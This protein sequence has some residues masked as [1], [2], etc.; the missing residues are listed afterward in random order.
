[1]NTNSNKKHNNLTS[2]LNHLHMPMMLLVAALALSA[3]MGCTTETTASDAGS[4]EDGAQTVD[5]GKKACR[6]DSKGQCPGGCDK[7]EVWKTDPVSQCALQPLVARTIACTPSPSL[8]SGVEWC[9][10]RLDGSEVAPSYGIS[11]IDATE[12]AAQ[13][14]RVCSAATYDKAQKTWNATCNKPNDK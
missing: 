10:E 14:W 3:A 7:V 1:M 2:H 9:Y 5:A 13:G 6:V 11:S 8:I 12:L 4:T